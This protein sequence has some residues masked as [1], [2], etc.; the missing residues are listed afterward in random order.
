M[1]LSLPH[2]ISNG[3]A[4][5]ADEVMANFNALLGQANGLALVGGSSSTPV[6]RANSVGTSNGTVGSQTVAV[7]DASAFLVGMAGTVYKSNSSG[8]LQV[9]MSLLVD[10]EAQLQQVWS[11]EA[12]LG[13]GDE[14][15]QTFGLGRVGLI[16]LTAGS[17]T[18]AVKWELAVTDATGTLATYALRGLSVSWA[19]LV[20]PS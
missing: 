5:D 4:P 8:S 3:S 20:V 7:D 18:V 13:S 12:A 11:E 16:S 9:T 15:I 14:M 17:H 2:N 1:S 6:N 19:G 10:G